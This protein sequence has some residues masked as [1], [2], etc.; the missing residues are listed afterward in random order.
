[1]LA[2]EWA[3]SL[4]SWIAFG[5]KRLKRSR[6][7]RSLTSH[8]KANNGPNTLRREA[9]KSTAL[10][11]W[12]CKLR[13]GGK[14]ICR[15]VTRV[16]GVR[17]G[18]FVRSPGFSRK[19]SE[20]S[21]FRLKPGLRTLLA[22]IAEQVLRQRDGDDRGGLGSENPRSEAHGSEAAGRGHLQ[23]AFAPAAF[24][25]HAEAEL[26]GVSQF[27]RDLSETFSASFGKDQT[28]PAGRRF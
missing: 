10:R 2:G 17:R 27:R 18:F 26:I 8:L 20:P 22:Q 11:E 23:F 25:R 21:P 19:G 15:V 24:G 5:W 13:P 7:K 14:T 1:M 4:N 28:C 3:W 9:T 16:L 12:T 6:T